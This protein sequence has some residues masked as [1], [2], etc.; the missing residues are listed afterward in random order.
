MIP[1]ITS[2]LFPVNYPN[3]LVCTYRFKY[4][5]SYSNR[6]CF[7]FQTIDLEESASCTADS[8]SIHDGSNE[9]APLLD[10]ICGTN[11]TIRYM[12]TGDSLFVKFKSNAAIAKQG[13]RARFFSCYLG[14]HTI[15]LFFL[16][17][18]QLDYSKFTF[19]FI[20]MSF[21]FIQVPILMNKFH[22]H[23]KFILFSFLFD[24]QGSFK[25]KVSLMFIVLKTISL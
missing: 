7:E 19:H 13:F 18:N 17:H 14:M 9:R 4:S 24:F 20:S 10:K 6:L 15:S 12:T 3:N 2:P 5:P 25:L 8:V 21:Y 11:S 23:F 22:F 1:S 16:F